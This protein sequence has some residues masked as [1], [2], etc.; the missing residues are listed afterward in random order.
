MTLSDTDGPSSV[1]KVGLFSTENSLSVAGKKLN[2]EVSEV[3]F[4]LRMLSSFNTEY[5]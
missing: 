1:S 2:T 5:V 4:L 3:R